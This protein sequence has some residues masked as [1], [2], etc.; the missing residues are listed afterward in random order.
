M[1]KIVTSAHRGFKTKT[2]REPYQPYHCPAVCSFFK[3]A[4]YIYISIYYTVPSVVVLS[5]LETP[6]ASGEHPKTRRA[7]GPQCRPSS[8]RLPAAQRK[9]VNHSGAKVLRSQ[10]EQPHVLLT[11]MWALMI[12]DETS[13]FYHL[14]FQTHKQR[15]AADF[16]H[17]NKGMLQHTVP[18]DNQTRLRWIESNLTGGE[19]LLA[20]GCATMP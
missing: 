3:T 5:H 14:R 9:M 1:T 6:P 18:W 4:A 17:I 7:A 2:K 11:T 16:K 8:A 12:H 15:H 19:R 20:G 10:L 13:F